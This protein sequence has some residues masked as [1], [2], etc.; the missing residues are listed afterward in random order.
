MLGAA[1]VTS[2]SAGLKTLDPVTVKDAIPTINSSPA[3]VNVRTPSF[4]QAQP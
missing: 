3:M 4:T 1:A 2:N